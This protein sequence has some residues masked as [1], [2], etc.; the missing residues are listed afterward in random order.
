M[1]RFDRLPTPIGGHAMADLAQAFQTAAAPANVY[2][3]QNERN[4]REQT[5][6][7]L[8]LAKSLLACGYRD[9]LGRK[10]LQQYA[11]DVHGVYRLYARAALAAADPVRPNVRVRK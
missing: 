11:E 1:D 5:L 3:N 7:E 8:L 6:R 4:V 10:I 2:D 9:G